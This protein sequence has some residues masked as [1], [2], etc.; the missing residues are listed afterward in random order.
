MA[1][2]HFMSTLGISKL[3]EYRI[4]AADNVT[5]IETTKSHTE[6]SSQFYCIKGFGQK[7]LNDKY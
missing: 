6:C 1:S 3:I 7:L 5:V 2:V 4:V